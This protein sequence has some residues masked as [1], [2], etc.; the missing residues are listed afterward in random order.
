MIVRASLSAST[1][2]RY[3]DCRTTLGLFVELISDNAESRAFFDHAG[4]AARTWDGRSAPVR[5]FQ[6]GR[7]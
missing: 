1:E 2:L 7:S 5:P 4:A 3:F 6:P